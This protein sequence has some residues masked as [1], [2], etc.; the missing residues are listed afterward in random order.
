VLPKGTPIAQCVPVK[1]ERWVVETTCFTEEKTRAVH[2]LTR[3]LTLE[4]GFYRRNF[5]A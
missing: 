2:E 3:S 1:R 5:R 4:P